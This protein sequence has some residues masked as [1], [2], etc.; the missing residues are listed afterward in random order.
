MREIDLMDDLDWAI[1]RR[2]VLFERLPEQIALDLVDGQSLVEC[3]KGE[4]LCRHGV[5]ATTCHVVVSGLVKLYRQG[6]AASSTILSMIAPGQPFMLAE[7]L[8]GKPYS[9]SAE[10]VSQARVLRIEAAHLRARITTDAPLAL[11]MLS[12]ASS[13]L[14]AMIAHVEELKTM[15]GPARLID[16]ILRLAGANEHSTEISLPYEKHLIANYLGMTPE[17]FSRALAMLKPHGVQV[18]QERISIANLPRFRA[19]IRTLM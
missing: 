4:T 9:A 2:S 17:S 16:F 7:G 13:H 15:T 11:A 14:R 10:T 1:I 18:T 8:I 3:A 5:V 12:S 19:A 6:D